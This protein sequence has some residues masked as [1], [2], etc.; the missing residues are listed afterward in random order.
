MTSHPLH[1]VKAEVGHEVSSEFVVNTKEIVTESII[2][3][4]N[5]RCT[6]D[7]T[8]IDGFYACKEGAVAEILCKSSAEPGTNRMI[9]DHDESHEPLRRRRMDEERRLIEELREYVRKEIEFLDE[10]RRCMEA[11][12]ANADIQ[13]SNED[14]RNGFT[15]FKET[16]GLYAEQ[17]RKQGVRRTYM[18]ADAKVVENQEVEEDLLDLDYEDYSHLVEENR[19]WNFP[20]LSDLAGT[21]RR[22]NGIKDD[23]HGRMNSDAP[24]ERVHG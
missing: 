10:I 20:F 1:N 14:H 3:V 13:I 2:D 7:N 21:S 4:V 9:M 22:C 16:L 23:Q 24:K 17:E 8:Q 11:E 18:L 5:E 15:D 6:I 19:S 12:M